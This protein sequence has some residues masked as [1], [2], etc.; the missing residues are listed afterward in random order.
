MNAL[1]LCHLLE[2]V[3][4]LAKVRL[5]EVLSSKYCEHCLFIVCCQEWE[6]RAMDGAL[7]GRHVLC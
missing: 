4:V 7:T 6:V 5:L 3:R 1:F 2:E